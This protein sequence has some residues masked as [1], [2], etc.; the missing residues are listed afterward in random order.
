MI[1][2]LKDHFCNRHKMHHLESNLEARHPQICVVAALRRDVTIALMLALL[3]AHPSDGQTINRSFVPLPE[4]TRYFQMNGLPCVLFWGTHHYGW[5]GYPSAA[6]IERTAAYANFITL[7]GSEHRYRD[8]ASLWAVAQD[9]AYWRQVR[10][11]VQA[12]ADRG[13]IVHFYFYDGNYSLEQQK[14]DAPTWLFVDGKLDDDLAA[15][16]LQGVTRRDIHTAMIDRGVEF[17]WEFPNVIFDP[18]FE[19][20]NTYRWRRYADQFQRWWVDEFKKRGSDHRKDVR[21]LFGTMWGGNG[22]YRDG[23]LSHKRGGQVE[24][25]PQDRHMD[26]LI[27]EHSQDGFFVEP[28]HNSAAVYGWRVPM[29]RMALHSP[30]WQKGAVHRPGG[31]AHRLMIDH[32]VSGIHTGE[33]YNFDGTRWTYEYTSPELRNWMLQT[34]WYLEN[35]RTWEDEPGGDEIVAQRLP[36]AAISA[37]PTLAPVDG[38]AAGARQQGGDVVFACRFLD[39]ESEPPALAEV[40]VDRNGD[41]RFSPNPA[42]AERVTMRSLGDGHYSAR[43]C[44]PSAPSVDY[45]FRFADRHWFPPLEGIGMVPKSLYAHR[46]VS[47][48]MAAEPPEAQ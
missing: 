26:L 41:G 32:I 37:R 10:Q 19:M 5:R 22:S 18:A 28:R 9:R 40:W 30:S 20:V 47:I 36:A 7:Q 31:P 16:G 39:P 34:R 11:S 29:V 4:N 23:R 2:D 15:F 14:Y 43:I 25:H 46:S 48:A 12:A 24:S 45:V 3:Q 1:V 35:I 27:G 8:Y 42:C 33:P 6:D 21:H 44:M 13:V 38:Y 17:V